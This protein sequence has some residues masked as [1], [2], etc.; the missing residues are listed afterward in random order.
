M[1]APGADYRAK[2]IRVLKRERLLEVLWEDDT[3]RRYAFAA[4][5]AGCRCA[6]CRRRGADA[7]AA[8]SDVDITDVRPVGA[9]AVQLVFSDGHER[10]IFPFR[11]LHSL[12]PAA[13]AA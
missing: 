3:L 5:R 1:S 11:Y 13:S 7:V 10:G 4:L 2:E 12:A 6:E 9:Y 8:Q